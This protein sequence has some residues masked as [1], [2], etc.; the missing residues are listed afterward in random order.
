MENSIALAAKAYKDESLSSETLQLMM[1]A[2]TRG[3]ASGSKAETLEYFWNRESSTV[4]LIRAQ[5]WWSQRDG[6]HLYQCIGD[7]N[8]A[9]KAKEEA[10]KAIRLYLEGRYGEC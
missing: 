10:L 7:V 8:S 2:A 5:L 9:K 3:Q 6:G 4:V 1:K